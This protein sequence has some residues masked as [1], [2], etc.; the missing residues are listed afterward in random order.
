[1]KSLQELSAAVDRTAAF[2]A[3]C[4]HIM[5][6]KDQ[7]PSTA[8]AMAAADPRC[9]RT[10]V[11]L[12]EKAAVSAGSTN[13]PAFAAANLVGVQASFIESLTRVSAFDAML[14]GGMRRAPLR[15]RL[16]SV[17]NAATGASP[18]EGAAKPLSTLTL[19]ATGIERRKA[20]AMIAL[21][22]DALRAGGAAVEN[23]LLAELRRA[24]SR[25]TN[26]T[27]LTLL[28]AAAAPGS[29][30]LTSTDFATDVQAMLQLIDIGETSKLFLIAE[31]KPVA[32]VRFARALVGGGFGDISLLASDALPS[33]T[34]LLV[35]ADAVVGSSEAIT[36]DSARHASLLMDN[37][38]TM[39][40]G[41][42]GS[43]DAP[44]GASLVSL[45]QTNS[46]AL[47]A[48]RYWGAAVV[49][50]DAVAMVEGVASD[51]A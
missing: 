31:P 3:L 27:F 12:L 41:G 16:V 21:T 46:V 8:A 1:M 49:G 36:V 38:P 6:A 10:T 20:T 7:G 2:S 42:I 28:A 26:S 45:F 39:S 4:K 47:R 33:G 32:A 50:T 37:A 48:E 25:A 9:P 35:D 34:A 30:S 43:P 40:S 14:Q 18:G 19:G 11:E 24:V 29:P 13:D 5:L 23:F 44:T 22:E 17:T 15:Q 51:W